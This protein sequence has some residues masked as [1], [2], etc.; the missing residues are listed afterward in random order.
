MM[1]LP[2]AAQT[3][4]DI[5]VM[6]GSDFVRPGLL[7]RANLNIGIGYSIDRM[8]RSPVGNEITFAYTYENGGSHGFWHTQN[9]SHT[10]A[11][12]IMKNFS[13][14][15]TKSFGGYTWGQAGLT[16][17]TGGPKGVQNRLYSGAALGIAYHYTD[18]Q[19]IWIQETYNKVATV[20]WYTSTGIGYV[21]SW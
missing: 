11:L 15:K 10:E 7:P 16:S 1:A 8:K 3:T 17:M 4:T 9:G 14:P 13:I 12:G 6:P 20:P 2:C 19:G 18:H 21:V 5:F